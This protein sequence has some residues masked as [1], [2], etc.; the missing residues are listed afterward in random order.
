MRA[1]GKR[2]GMQ[3]TGCYRLQRVA[4]SSLIIHSTCV[5]FYPVSFLRL[6]LLLSFTSSTVARFSFAGSEQM[7]GTARCGVS[8]QLI[9]ARNRVTDD[10]VCQ[11]RFRLADGSVGECGSLLSEHVSE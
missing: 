3:D 1:E 8:Q 11:M 6:T 2:H 9:V 7:S 4:F 10:E 5:V